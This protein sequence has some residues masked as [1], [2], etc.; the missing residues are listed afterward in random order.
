MTDTTTTDTAYEGWAI[1]ELMGHRQT[2]GKIAQVQMYGASLLRVDTP[3]PDGGT[4][5]SQMYSGAA[6]YCVTPCTEA[7]A[8]R[9]LREAY[10][11]PPMVA[12]A[13]DA[14]ERRSAP[15]QIEGPADDEPDENDPVEPCL[16]CGV[17]TTA[18][19]DL[20][21]RCPNFPF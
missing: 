3:K 1:V 12:L 11:L 10:N 14:Q 9:A 7:V 8:Q 19:C 15:P 17:R 4:M 13:I 20:G 5:V 21:T 16:E 18:A 6:I 2:A